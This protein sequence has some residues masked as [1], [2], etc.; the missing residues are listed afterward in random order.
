MP[1]HDG[2]P[3]HSEPALVG[4]SYYSSDFHWRQG[5]YVLTLVGLGLFALVAVVMSYFDVREHI[6]S[7]K[8]A[9]M[10]KA[11]AK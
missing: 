3:P 9:T 4:I 1:L 6:A 5:L 2:A 8:A 7:Q 10:V 11:A